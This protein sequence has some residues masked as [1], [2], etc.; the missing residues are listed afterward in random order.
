MTRL[1]F[2]YGF[3][4]EGRSE[5]VVYGSDEHLRDMLEL[6][7]LTLVGERVMRPDLGSPVLQMVFAGGEGP[8]ALALKSSLEAAITQWLGHVLRLEGLT[9]SFVEAD[10][11]L[12]I[13]VRYE[14][15]QTNIPGEL[16]VLKA[17]P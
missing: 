14:S 15:R 6:L 12:E 8:K 2:P 16:T 1:A 7:I 13:V 9:A 4:A 17:L 10:A 11:V 3:D 5:R